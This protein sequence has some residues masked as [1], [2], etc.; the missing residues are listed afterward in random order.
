MSA[1]ARGGIFYTAML[2]IRKLIPFPKQI[3]SRMR[4]AVINVLSNKT[5]TVFLPFFLLSFFLSFSA[6]FFWVDVAILSAQHLR[7]AHITWFWPAN[8]GIGVRWRQFSAQKIR[9]IKQQEREER[10]A[11]FKGRLKG[12][13]AHM[14][15]QDILEISR[16]IYSG[17][18]PPSLRAVP[19][20]HF[21]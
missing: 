7:H 14:H 3:Q 12:K 18:Q 9:R 5:G 15:G 2:P 6:W 21:P 20:K 13:R 1:T 4:T 16:L 10:K 8:M 19:Q 17:I 11:R